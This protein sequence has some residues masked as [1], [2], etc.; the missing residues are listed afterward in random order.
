[1]FVPKGPTDKKSALFQIMLYHWIGA[2]P[3]PE[4]K[5]TNIHDA[6]QPQ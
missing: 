6:V 3:F 4:L 1:M 5:M 2:K